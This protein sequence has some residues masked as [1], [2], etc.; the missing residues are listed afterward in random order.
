MQKVC[1]GRQG[2]QI[3]DNQFVTDLMFADDS[4]IFADSDAEANDI[5]REIA[6]I[7]LPYG[8]T[9][10]AEKTTALTTDRPPCTLFLDNSQI[11]QVAEFKYLGSAAEQSLM[12]R[13]NP[14]QNWQG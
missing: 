14:Q 10:N 7:A 13:G 2:V 4:A 5:L 1:S 8:L 11:E 9:K 6:A 3:G 12:H